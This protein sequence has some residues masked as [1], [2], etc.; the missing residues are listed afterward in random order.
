MLLLIQKQV[1][2]AEPIY[3][4]KEIQPY[5]LKK[6]KNYIIYNRSDFQQ[7]AKD[8]YYR[9]AEKLV[10]KFISNKLIFAYDDSKSLFL[11]S[12]NILI[13]SIPNMSVKTVMGFLNSE[14]YQ[15]LYSTLFFEMKI[16]KGT[17]IELPFPAISSVQNDIITNYVQRIISGERNYIDRL[18]NVIYSVF[19]ISEEQKKYIKGKVYGTFNK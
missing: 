6:N 7:V 3:T 9:V 5:C 1:D 16:L 12:A 17:L 11:N 8:E 15:Y 2:G 4:G 13:P 10:Y 18:Q 14:L 19:D